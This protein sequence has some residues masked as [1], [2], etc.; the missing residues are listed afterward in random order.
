MNVAVVATAFSGYGTLSI[1]DQLVRFLE[2]CIGDDH[3]YFFVADWMP[4]Y[5][6]KN[7]RYVKISKR[8][9]LFRL[10]FDFFG[11]KKQ[12]NRLG[13]KW[14]VVISL[15]NIGI[16]YSKKVPQIVY[17]QQAL[18]LYH[19]PMPLTDK[20]AKTYFFYHYIYSYYIKVMLKNATHVA[21]QTEVMKKRFCNR[22]RFPPKNVGVY[23]PDY[24]KCDVYDNGDNPFDEGTFNFIFPATSN[25]Y[26]EH[27]TIAK[28]LVEV[29]KA[30]PEL[31]RRI[32]VHFTLTIDER[33]DLTNFIRNNNL[34]D[35]FCFHGT[36]P[37][38]QLMA[39]YNRCIAL[40]FPSVIESVG[41]PLIEAA[42]LGLPV[43]ANDID[44]IHEVLY[45]YEGVSYME[46]HNYIQWANEIVS[47][48]IKKERYT[49]LVYKNNNSWDRFLKTIG[50]LYKDDK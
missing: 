3:Y 12:S 27:I 36:M 23:F 40:L 20:F 22:Y 42:T 18:T 29:R 37:H 9:G 32:R 6:I 39:L 30:N 13:I 4:T 44:F 26:K 24:Q 19:Y 50:S 2:N 43:I 46:L 33:G 31:C 35:C 11:F 17:F 41:L 38:D 34:E 1:Y 10:Y 16:R 49:P 48:C 28:A 5:P 47:H 21:I 45:N 8:K 7:V 15:Q 14:D 25:A